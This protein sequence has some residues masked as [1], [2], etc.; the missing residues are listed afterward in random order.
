LLTSWHFPAGAL[1]KKIKGGTKM[2]LSSEVKITKIKDVSSTAGTEVISDEID[3]S[4]FDGCLFFTTI[5][6]ANAGN[7]IKAQEDDTTGMASAA[8]LADTKVVAA[9][10]NDVVWLDIYKP[11]K[12]FLRLSVIRAG[13]NTVVG[14]IYALQYQGR[15]FPIS[16][17]VTNSII[18]ELHISPVAGTA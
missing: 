2:N 3:M 9:S 15:K 7:Y 17:L 1:L 18:G 13:T 14:E 4:G 11:L 5:A 8:D 6:T 12:R 16:N 10:T